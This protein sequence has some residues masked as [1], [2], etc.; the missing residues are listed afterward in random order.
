MK[1]DTVIMESIF[2]KT[3]PTSIHLSFPLE[4]SPTLFLPLTLLKQ[5]KSLDHPAQSAITY[6]SLVHSSITQIARKLGLDI[7]L[8]TRN[9]QFTM[10]DV[11]ALVGEGRALD[12][13]LDLCRG[14][15]VIVD[16]IT[17]LLYLYPLPSIISFLTSLFSLNTSLI[18][19]TNSDIPV[20][21]NTYINTFIAHNT[22]KKITLVALKSG[23]SSHVDG[24]IVV[25]EDVLQYKV[26]ENGCRVFGRGLSRDVL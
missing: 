2:N 25:G 23:K 13:V 6:I 22:V 14:D 10:H 9:G 21:A 16:C 1:C 8:M 19:A 4:C 11:S 17:P 7:P 5:Y 24:E 12:E 15:L 3:S 18:L 20:P 26:G